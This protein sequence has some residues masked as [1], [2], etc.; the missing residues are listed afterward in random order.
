[1][2]V[3]GSL[4]LGCGVRGCDFAKDISPHPFLLLIPTLPQN[5]HSCLVSHGI[6]IPLLLQQPSQ[7]MPLTMS[8]FL[9]HC[10]SVSF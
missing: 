5:Y 7:M 2:A 9:L 4:L 3:S 10:T 1:M 6:Q 8:L